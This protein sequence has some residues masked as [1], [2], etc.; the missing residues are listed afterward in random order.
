[1]VQSSIKLVC[2]ILSGMPQSSH[3]CLNQADSVL[4]HLKYSPACLSSQQGTITSRTSNLF[5]L[6][7]IKNTQVLSNP[8]DS[9][10]S[11]LRTLLLRKCL[12]A[13]AALLL[14]II[15]RY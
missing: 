10:S 11:F 2:S 3:N 14:E 8:D 12:P 1:M 9:P 6:N 5:I 13:E 4:Y 15:V 7:I